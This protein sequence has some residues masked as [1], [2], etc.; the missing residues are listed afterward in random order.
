MTINEVIN[1]LSLEMSFRTGHIE[2][3]RIYKE[4]LTMALTIG[5]DH[6][7]NCKEEIIAMTRDGVELGRFKSVADAAKKL[8]LGRTH[9][10]D[11]LSHRHYSTGGYLFIRSKDKELIK[12]RPDEIT[13]V[14]H[15]Y[16]GYKEH[17]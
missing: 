1:K 8:G 13:E 12:K 6:F 5:H 15:E 2:D 7:I 4:Y 17:Q 3:V 14:T 10:Q 9:I 16:Q 11:V